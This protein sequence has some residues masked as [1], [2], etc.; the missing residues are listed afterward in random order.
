MIK[1]K[2]EN[3][4]SESE[5]YSE[6]VK[7]KKQVDSTID[8]IENDIESMMRRARSSYE[9][10]DYTESLDIYRSIIRD[11]SESKHVTE[12]KSLEVLCEIDKIFN[13]KYSPLPELEPAGR[14]ISK[15]FDN[16]VIEVSNQTSFKVQFFY[17]GID[18]GIV[19]Y[20]AGSVGDI[21]F[22]QGKYKL[23]TRL[24]GKKLYLFAQ[25]IELTK[26]KYSLLF[27]E[28]NK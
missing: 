24:L 2:L 11:F 6:A 8:K 21:N 17:Y 9:R 27:Y 1:S 26:G 15:V 10:R 7:L 13:R 3:I 23:A 16:V 25:E 4:C 5:Y 19:E 28:K 18:A 20:K 22:T 12:C 14:D